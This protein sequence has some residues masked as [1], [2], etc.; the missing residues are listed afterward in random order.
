L[1]IF[2]RGGTHAGILTDASVVIQTMIHT[3]VLPAQIPGQ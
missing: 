3:T 2:L 1:A